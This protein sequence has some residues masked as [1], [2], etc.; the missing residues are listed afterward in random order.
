MICTRKFAFTAGVFACLLQL[1]SPGTA[2]PDRELVARAR[3]ALARG[4]GIAA[5]A[6]LHRLQQQG[7]PRDTLAAAMGEALIQ[8]GDRKQAREWLENEVFATSDQLLGYR[9]LGLLERLDGNLGAAGRAYDKALKVAPQDAQLW[10]DI[11]RLRY[12]GGEQLLAIAAAEQAVDLDPENVRALEFRAQLVRDQF[13][14]DAALP[15]LEAALANAPNDPELLAQYAAT[16]GDLG[17]ARDMLVVTRRLVAVSPRHPMGYLLQAS[18][19]ARAGKIELARAILERAG[20]RL[21]TIPAATLLQGALELEAENSAFAVELLDGLVQRQPGNQRAQLLL[22]RAMYQAGDY[23]G[24]IQRFAGLAAR[25]DAPA[26]LLTLLARAYEDEDDRLAA[27]PLLDRA[28]T[29]TLMPVIANPFAD[30][31]AVPGSATALAFIG[32][33]NLA[34]GRPLAALESYA[35]SARIRFSENL[36]LRMTEANLALG[37]LDANSPLVSGY[38]A[39]HP[40]NRLA[41]RMAAGYAAQAGD[42]ERCAALL[43]YLR[44]AGSARDV[45][46]LGDLTIA[47]LR[48]GDRVAALENAR[49]A[50][51]LQRGSALTTQAYAMALI[52]N[53]DDLSLA[54]ELLDKAQRIGGDNPLLANA[55]KQL[56]AAHN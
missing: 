40:G 24:V 13:G 19:A 47:R 10:V 31:S 45:R 34:N 12:A 7:A 44:Q 26:Y 50:Y 4:D 27:A 20:T 2:A 42:W 49:T 43:G 11:G 52:A 30:G 37:R 8:Q 22:A 23:K 39:S 15:W 28:A 54:A 41:A 18:L 3:A 29:A 55:R 32:D 14:F 21:R 33:Q 36:V 5:E 1:A 48:G 16:L 53:R 46:L 35:L 6:D 51:A 25:A 17:R 38:L 9:M 56:A